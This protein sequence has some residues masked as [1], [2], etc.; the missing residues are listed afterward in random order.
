MSLR[1]IAKHGTATEEFSPVWDVDAET[2]SHICSA[3]DPLA[4]Y[5]CYVRELE[6]IELEPV[7]AAD[8]IDGVGQPVTWMQ[9]GKAVEHVDEVCAW[10]RCLESRGFMLEVLKC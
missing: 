5:C 9:Y 8:D 1:I 10:A 4:A 2:A 7:Y 6:P 3:L